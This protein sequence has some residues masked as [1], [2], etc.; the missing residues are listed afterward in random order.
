MLTL[1]PTGPQTEDL[2]SR[3]PGGRV[4]L[5]LLRRGQRAG[6]VPQNT[7]EAV[8]AM[9][10]PLEAPAAG[11]AAGASHGLA[12][13]LPGLLEQIHNYVHL[14]PQELQMLPLYLPELLGHA[15]GPHHRAVHEQF[16]APLVQEIAKRIHGAPG[17]ALMAATGTD[18]LLDWLAHSARLQHPLERYTVMKAATPLGD[19][20][21]SGSDT[22]ADDPTTR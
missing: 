4:V 10:N 6:F 16:V 17:R 19:T 13:L 11:V 1:Q 14:S 21:V 20:G 15:I 5:N 2:Y 9:V 7:K 8:Q 18:T 3:L 22:T 12:A